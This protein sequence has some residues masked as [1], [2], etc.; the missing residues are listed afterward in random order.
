M[1]ELRRCLHDRL[2]TSSMSLMFSDPLPF[3]FK[4]LEE[5]LINVVRSVGLAH[6]LAWICIR[7]CL[8]NK[9]HARTREIVQRNSS[10]LFTN[11]PFKIIFKFFYVYSSISSIRVSLKFSTRITKLKQKKIH[12]I[13]IYYPLIWTWK[14]KKIP[15]C[16]EKKTN[17]RRLVLKIKIPQ[18][19]AVLFMLFED[20]SVLFVVLVL[21]ACVCVRKRETRKTDK[22]TSKFE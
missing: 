15:N 18:T 13:N 10:F 17:N 1:E 12:S 7:S 5:I 20:L 14:K 2:K 3:E 19:G 4:V 21:D 22:D 11:L 6:K 8:I 16:E 9:A